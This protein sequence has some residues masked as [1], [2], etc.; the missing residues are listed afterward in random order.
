M[1]VRPGGS[2]K[3]VIIVGDISRKK[4]ASKSA[5]RMTSDLKKNPNERGSKYI[6]YNHADTVKL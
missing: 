1:I 5:N 6:T 2:R 3:R 4:D